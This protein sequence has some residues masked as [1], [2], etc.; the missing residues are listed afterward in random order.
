MK[1]YEKI[2][3]LA[4]DGKLPKNISEDNFPDIDIFVEL[5]Q[6]GF[7][8]AIDASSLDGRVYLNPKI[9]FD[10]R[11][12]FNGL[13][14]TQKNTMTTNKN[15]A[16][17]VFISYVRENSDEVEIICNRFSKEGI[18]YWIDREQIEAGKF[19]KTAITDAINNGG[20]FLACFSREHEEKAE[21]HMNEEILLAIEILRKKTFNSGWFIPIKLTDCNIPNYDI[22]PGKTLQD[23]QHLKFY[24][25][26]DTELERLVDVIKRE[27]EPIPP[28]TDKRYVENEYI[29]KG[30]KSLIETGS[31]W[32][33]HNADLGHPVY[34]LGASDASEDTLKA[35]EYADSPEKSRLFKML[36]K[37]SKEL[38]QS[39]IEEFQYIW[40]YDFSEWKDFCKFAMDIYNKR[41]GDK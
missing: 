18:E 40:W 17:K 37:L 9:T 19:W 12:Y 35:W 16:K 7:V 26:W 13:E 28:D 39:G 4:I 11:E 41:R 15:G 33:F 3:R 21:T 5:Y 10:G 31:G 24:E 6:R 38:K 25:D 29:Y 1:R 34:A 32:G 30:L 27:E 23:I 20:C 2:L 8:D 14:D 22:A 36:S